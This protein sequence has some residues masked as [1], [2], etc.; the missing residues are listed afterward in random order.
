MKVFYTIF[1]KPNI[2]GTRLSIKEDITLLNSDIGFVAVINSTPI[3]VE[4]NV[5]NTRPIHT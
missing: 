3:V 1:I 5:I 2:E 4:E